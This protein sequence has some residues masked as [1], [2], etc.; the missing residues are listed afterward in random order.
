MKAVQILL[1]EHEG[2]EGL[3]PFALTHC[4]WE[5][6]TGLYTIL[7]RWQKTIPET[8]VSVVSHR[9]QHLRSFVERYPDTHAFVQ[10]HTLL[11]AGNVLLSPSVMRQLVDTCVQS[12]SSFLVTCG[13]H[14]VGAYIAEP[15]PSPNHAID[16]L[17]SLDADACPTVECTGTIINRLW[18][19]LDHIDASITWDA[20]L[21]DRLISSSA[22]VHTTAVL[23][24]SAGPIII[25]DGARVDPFV[26]VKGPVAIGRDTTVK[27]H[28]SLNAVAIGPTCRVAGE[29]ANSIIQGFTNK[30][31]DGFLGHSYLGEWVNL[32]AG[33][34]T[35]NLKNTYGHINVDMPWGTEDTQRMFIG[36]MIGDHSKAGIGTMFSTGTVC[37]VSNNIVS[38]G[39]PPKSIGSFRW[40]D[41]P[42]NV[43]KAIAVMHTVMGRRGMQLGPET[44]A[45]LRYLAG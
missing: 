10:A 40:L 41:E 4:S 21:V 15:L 29:C 9:D 35:S 42:Y 11:I 27:P 22:T 14:P 19:T 24:D 8:T 12:T 43:N 28:A 18:Q 31:H 2:V 32:G 37:G 25:D 5:M 34:T 39:P 26:V 3:Y 1:V 33:T 36:L 7:E 16:H 13:G 17:E 6:R 30:A 23:D 20:R 45:L 38:V 44:E